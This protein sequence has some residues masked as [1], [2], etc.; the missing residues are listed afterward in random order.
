MKTNE[1]IM[2]QRRAFIK[3]AGRGIMLAGLAGL[4]G[5]LLFREQSAEACTLDFVCGNCGKHKTCQ[6]PEAQDY[7][8]GTEMAPEQ[9]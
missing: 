9:H 5:Y 8:N 7:R 4:S 6:L 3:K 1:T 2:N